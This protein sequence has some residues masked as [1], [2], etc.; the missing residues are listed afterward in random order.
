[1]VLPPDR[2]RLVVIVADRNTRQKHAARARVVTATADGCGTAEVIRSL[3]LSR[4][5]IWRRQERFMQQGCDD[6]LRDNTRK[7][8]KPLLPAETV[9]RVPELTLSCLPGA[10]THCSVRAMPKAAG[11]GAN[12]VQRI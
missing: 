6:L 10:T 2:I 3:G 1:M 9:Q 11:T 7:P 8:C 4:T 5:V 12:R